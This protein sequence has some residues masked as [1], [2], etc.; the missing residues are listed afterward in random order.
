MI[1]L[2]TTTPRYVSSS[3]SQYFWQSPSDLT[4]VGSAAS[5]AAYPVKLSAPVLIT[6]PVY[7]MSYTSVIPQFQSCQN[8][9]V[10]YPVSKK[11]KTFLQHD[12][13]V[14]RFTR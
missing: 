12:M 11:A 6:S 5:L 14:T 13:I 4:Y 10:G 9:A 2:R 1:V 8:F 7:T 3:S